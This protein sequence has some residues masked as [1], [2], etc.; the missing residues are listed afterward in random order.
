MPTPRGCGRVSLGSP[1]IHRLYPQNECVRHGVAPLSLQV[2]SRARCRG[3]NGDD[4]IRLAWNMGSSVLDSRRNR[5]RSH[6]RC[7]LDPSAFAV[8][9]GRG[10]QCCSL[11]CHPTRRCVG[12]RHPLM[13][14]NMPDGQS[15]VAN[16]YELR[17]HDGRLQIITGPNSEPQDWC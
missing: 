15:F 14:M 13:E 6:Q 9:A 1:S 4:G 11:T 12:A 8:Y 5:R 2:A 16:D 10:N 17:R 7:A 3:F